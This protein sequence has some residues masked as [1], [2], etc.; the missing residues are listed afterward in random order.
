F[1]TGGIRLPGCTSSNT[2]QMQV[3]G[4]AAVPASTRFY[5]PAVA[6]PG[7]LRV[8]LTSDHP[9]AATVPTEAVVPEGAASTSFAIS[10]I[11]VA[12]ATTVKITGTINPSGTSASSTHGI[13]KVMPPALVDL[14]LSQTTVSA[15]AGSIDAW[16]ELSG[17]AAAGTA[18]PFNLSSTLA[19]APSNIPIN[20]GADRTSF[21]ITLKPVTAPTQVNV[22]AFYG[23]VT[24]SVLLTITP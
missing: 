21:K 2:C 5:G 24:K 10:T 17:P 16:I 13:V 1:T 12:Q 14:R 15:Q 7:G 18:I 19:S 11:P 9:S 22:S 8:T 3:Q 4:G 6:P 23:G 20:A